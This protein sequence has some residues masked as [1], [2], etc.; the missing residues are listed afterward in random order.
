MSENKIPKVIH[1]CWFS[2]DE[3]SPFILD[4][5]KSWSE[6]M[7]DYQIR[8][9]D[10]NSF[11]F[12]S[13]PFVHEAFKARKWAFV[14]DYIRL[15]ALYTEGGV[16]L[17]SD[18]KVF[19]SFS[20]FLD[21]DFFTSHELHPG[22]FTDTEKSKL[23]KNF[24]PKN[25]NDLVFGLNVQAA[26]MAAKKGNLYLKDCLEF[27]QDKHLIDENNTLL[28]E[29]FIIGPI[30]SK[31]AEKYGY[32]YQDS[33][34][35]LDNNMIIFKSDIFVGNSVFLSP[36]SYA[37]HLINGSWREK[38]KYSIFFSYVRNY[39]PRLF[40]LVDFNDRVM[41]NLRGLLKLN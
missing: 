20:E 11:D 36:K 25:E 6:I 5:M 10:A 31:I 37:I 16:Y 8:L 1:Y 2:G 19:K 7:P 26:I 28:C 4:C 27:Y 14:A 17:D 21:Y 3:K 15:Y 29:E 24:R 40:F 30:I 9:W 33:E 38:S 23:D 22:N 12:S 35:K 32:V 18:V 13:V 41:R 34:Q 39:Y